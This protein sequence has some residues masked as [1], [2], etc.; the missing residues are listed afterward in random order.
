MI[1]IILDEERDRKEGY[2]DCCHI[3]ID[4]RGIKQQKVIR[5]ETLYELLE[6]TKE[7]KKKELFLGRMPRGYLATKLQIEDFPKI[8][9][10]TAIFLEEDVRRIIYENN[11]Y[12]IPIPN[13]FM[14]HSVT[15]K[16]C[17]STDLFCLEKDMD[18]KKTAKLLEEGRTPNL[19]RWPF[20][21]VNNKGKVCYGSNSIRKIEKLSDLDIL[22]ILFFDSPMNSDYYNLQRTTLKKATIRELLD[23]LNGEKEFPYEILQKHE[24][25]NYERS[26]F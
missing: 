25:F 2:I 14:I 8:Q 16:G 18:Q 3:I 1:Q 24:S 20:A 5:T 9:S 19:Y 23:T 17:V 10:K 15:T 22:P 7:H 26:I 21:N 11:V 12:E 4:D 13:L 6:K